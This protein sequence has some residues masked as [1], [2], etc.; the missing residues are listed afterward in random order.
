[1]ITTE[2]WTL[3]PWT[4]GPDPDDLELTWA[5]KP[6]VVVDG[7]RSCPE[8]AVL[9]RLR[10]DGWDGFWVNAYRGE[11]R[12]DWFPAPAVS[13]VDVA[14]AD[15]AAIFERLRVA[16]GGGLGGFLDVFAWRDGQ[17]RFVEVKFGR[18]EWRSNQQRFVDMVL[19]LGHDLN[20]FLLV[21][22]APHQPAATPEQD[23]PPEAWGQTSTGMYQPGAPPAMAGID[24]V[25]LRCADLDATRIFYEALGLEFMEE[26]H[27]RGPRHLSTRL[28]EAVLE[29]YPATDR[30]PVDGAS[31]GIVT[32]G[33]VPGGPLTDP[34]GR[35]VMVRGRD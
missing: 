27:G 28:G 34:D 10:L 11:L 3:E 5:R 1:M 22:V 12:Q 8:L 4:G 19:G 26:R 2:R 24:A 33:P 21:E 30:F 17:V 13:T 9:A 25:V 23:R 14:P 29:L 7:R 15:V 6:K 18:D 20:D 31:V 16:N 32:D 35:H